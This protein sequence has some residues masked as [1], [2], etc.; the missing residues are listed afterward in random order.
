MQPRAQLLG[1]LG[2]GLDIPVDAEHLVAALL[3]QAGEGP[4]ARSEV[5]DPGPALTDQ[6]GHGGR[7]VER[8]PA[9]RHGSNSSGAGSPRRSRAA[10]RSAVGP[11]GGPGRRRPAV[12][13]SGF[14]FPDDRAA[15]G[16]PAGRGRGECR[17]DRRPGALAARGGSGGHGAVVAERGDPGGARSGAGAGPCPGGL[18]RGPG[19]SVGTDPYGARGGRPD[20]GAGRAA[21]RIEPARRGRRRWCW[22]RWRTPRSPPSGR[23]A[24]RT[25]WSL[26]PS[27]GWSSSPPGSIR[28]AAS[29]L[30]RGTVRWSRTTSPASVGYAQGTVTGVRNWLVHCAAALVEAAGWAPC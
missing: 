18:R 21:Q 11:R 10:G 24:A 28:R 26:A 7:R 27:N 23:S 29:R 2:D 17:D 15:R 6:P 16:R 25:A 8:S 5:E 3:Q 14:A 22:P 20:A 19:R 12:A 30:R 4:G 1:Q 9:R 13:R